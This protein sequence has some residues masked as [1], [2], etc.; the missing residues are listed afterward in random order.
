[1]TRGW[2]LTRRDDGVDARLVDDVGDLGPGD[3]TVEV[4]WSGINYKDA[5][6]FTGNPGVMRLDP[7]VP[8]ID[9]VGRVSASDDARWTIGDRVL[10]NG[11]GAGETHHGGL[12]ERARVSGA[13]LVAVP[14][15]LTDR[16]AAGI[17]TAGFT[18]MLAVLS[19]EDHAAPMDSVLVT[20]AS[21]G[22]GSFAIALLARAGATVIASSGRPEH[23]EHLRRLGAAEIIDRDELD[24]DSRPLDTQTYSAAIDSVGGRTLATIL[25]RTRHGGTVASCGLAGGSELPTTVMPFILRAVTLTGINSVHCPTVHRERAWQRLARDLNAE[26]I[27]AIITETSLDDAR[28]AAASLLTGGVR[29]RIAVE[30]RGASR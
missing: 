11:D 7:L 27:D 4:T 17:G 16:Q 22:V 2:Q 23:V 6:A 1:M 28:A 19:L 3:V 25:S 13:A 10:L 24:V 9:L 29:G 18:A 5:L 21:G 14:D 20:G 15:S 30:V 26:V 12:A 8:G